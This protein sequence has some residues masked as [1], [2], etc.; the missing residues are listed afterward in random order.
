M[1]SRGKRDRVLGPGTFKVWEVA[2][3]IVR[4]ICAFG[5]C[6]RSCV[7]QA[8]GH[9]RLAACAPRTSFARRF[10]HALKQWQ[11]PAF[12]LP[13]GSSQRYAYAQRLEPPPQD[14]IMLLCQN[15]RRRHE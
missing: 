9:D 10:L 15:L 13:R 11:W 14:I 1:I 6:T 2:A 7:R 12:L 5:H 8:A 3:M 4:L